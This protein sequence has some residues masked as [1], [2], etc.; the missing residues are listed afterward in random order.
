MP[1]T[2]ERSVPASDGAKIYLYSSG[3]TGQPKA[4]VIDGNKLW[5]AGYAF[6]RAH[7]IDYSKPFRIWNYLPQSYLGGLFNLCLIPISVAGTVVVDEFF[8]GKTLLGFWQNIDRYEIN[9]LWFVPTIVRGLLSISVRTR[10]HELRNYGKIVDCAFLGTAPIEIATKEQF[11]QIFG[12]ELIENYALSETTFLTSE[13]VG[14]KRSQGSVGRVLPYAELRFRAVVD[15]DDPRYREILART[16]FLADGYLSLGGRIISDLVDGFLPTG[17]LGYLNSSGCLVVTGRC[18][19]IIK[20]GG[21]FV[22]L[23]ESELIAASHPAVSEAVAVPIAHSF[24]GESYRLL[25]QLKPSTEL[26]DIAAVSAFI[27]ENLAKHK[28]PDSIDAVTE[29]PRTPSGKVRKFL[30]QN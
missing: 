17:D 28:W 23:R 20:K 2:A 26:E 21:H 12:I 18:K 22:A 11:E 27:L 14:E 7:D 1:E 24:Y 16:P 29:F 15:D 3:T 5:S 30:L 4:I 10:R 6:I 9:A 13:L 8:S 19:D 25:L